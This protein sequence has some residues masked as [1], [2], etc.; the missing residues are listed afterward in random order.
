L[1]LSEAKVEEGAPPDADAIEALPRRKLML[2][3]RWIC[4]LL[5]C[6]VYGTLYPTSLNGSCS[7]ADRNSSHFSSA[8]ACVSYQLPPTSHES[9]FFVHSL[10]FLALDNSEEKLVSWG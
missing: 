5:L 1:P 4:G 2:V 3:I 8:N 6:E 7:Q 10:N 9:A